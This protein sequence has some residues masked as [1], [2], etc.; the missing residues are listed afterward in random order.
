MRIK[1]IPTGGLGNR[2]RAIASGITI[3][4]H[5]QASVEILWNVRKGLHAEFGQLFCPLDNSSIL[6]TTNTSWLYNIEFR[7]E[8]LL[9]LPFLRLASSK[10]LYNFNTYDKKGKDIFQTIGNKKTKELVLISGNAMCKDYDMKSLFV[11]CKDIQDDIEKVLSRFSDN[12]IGIH[13]RRTD[14]KKSIK[15]SPLA[16]F[17]SLMD[18]EIEKDRSI[19]F[20][21]ATDDENV[22]HEMTKRFP[23]RIITQFEKA[24]RD[25]LE[26]MRFAVNDLYCLSKTKKIIGSLY[27]SYSHIASELGHIPIEYATK[28]ERAR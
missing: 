15:L 5:Y 7:K 3:A 21:L 13:I 22:K 1:I 10:V 19:Q 27:S 28:K 9:R 6:M 16:T 17:Y 14:N 12:T 24:D 2:M 18:T 26:G 11:P 8:Y 20:Y 4:K 23:N 25:S